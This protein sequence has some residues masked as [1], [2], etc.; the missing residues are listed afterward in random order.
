MINAFKKRQQRKQEASSR[1]QQ[2]TNEEHPDDSRRHQYPQKAWGASRSG[3]ITIAAAPPPSSAMQSSSMVPSQTQQQNL[4]LVLPPASDYRQSLIMPHLTRRFTFLRAPDGSLVS[5]DAMRAHLRAQRARARAATATVAPGTEHPT[6]FL[7]E[8]EENEIIEQ[9]KAQARAEGRDFDLESSLP[10]DSWRSGYAAGTDGFG[11]WGPTGQS[12]SNNL[13]G[14]ADSLGQLECSNNSSVDANSAAQSSSDRSP[15]RKFGG[16]L[17]TARSAER[18]QAY[19]RNVHKERQGSRSEA[20]RPTVGDGSDADALE[21]EVFTDYL[22][23]VASS[24]ID[25]LNDATPM[26]QTFPS[27][28]V[29]PGDFTAAEKPMASNSLLGVPGQGRDRHDR[30]SQDSSLLTTLSPKAFHR[31]STA[32]D[33]VYKLMAAERGSSSTSALGRSRIETAAI[34]SSVDSDNSFASAVSRVNASN[35]HSTHIADIAEDG[36]GSVNGHDDDDEEEDEEGLDLTVMPSGSLDA[37]QIENA[38]LNLAGLSAFDASAT[39]A[40]DQPEGYASRALPISDSTHTV[41]AGDASSTLALSGF[42]GANGTLAASGSSEPSAG[43]MQSSANGKVIG[44]LADTNGGRS[45]GR[46]SQEARGSMDEDQRNSLLQRLRSSRGSHNTASSSSHPSNVVASSSASPPRGVAS[47]Y[48]TH[49]SAELDSHRSSYAAGASPARLG[50]HSRKASAELLASARV[51]ASQLREQPSLSSLRRN[52]RRH[53][54]SATASSDGSILNGFAGQLP[55]LSP[56]ASG[57]MSPVPVLNR[58][59]RSTNYFP[60]PSSSNS[61]HEYASGFKPP[62]A[63][64]PAAAAA[65]QT[66]P[67]SQQGSPASPQNAVFDASH[68]LRRV[69][70]MRDSVST[71]PHPSSPAAPSVPS[72]SQSMDRTFPS[73]SSETGASSLSLG[74]KQRTTS[75]TSPFIVSPSSFGQT[76]FQAQLSPGEM[77]LQHRPVAPPVPSKDVGGENMLMPRPPDDPEQAEKWRAIYGSK[78]ADAASFQASSDDVT[79]GEVRDLETGEDEEDLWT[80]MADSANGLDSRRPVSNFPANL[81]EDQLAGTGITFDQLADYQNRLVQSAQ[82]STIPPLPSSTLAVPGPIPASAPVPA[83]A[84]GSTPSTFAEAKS[85]GLASPNLVLESSSSGWNT[86]ASPPASRTEE[87]ATALSTGFTA[88]SAPVNR[89]V[90]QTSR[91]AAVRFG[92]RSASSST[93]GS[94]TSPRAVL[95]DVTTSHRPTS[96]PLHGRNAS[97]TGLPSLYELNHPIS[98]SNR[99]SLSLAQAQRESHALPSSDGHANFASEAWGSQHAQPAHAS[100]ASLHSDRGIVQDHP[101]NVGYTSPIVSPPS[102]AEAFDHPRTSVSGPSPQNQSTHPG[103]QTVSVDPERGHRSRPSGLDAYAYANTDQLLDD[104]AAQARAATRALKGVDDGSVATP[105]HRTKSIARKKSFR[106]V[107]KQ[108]S[109]PQLISTSQK[110]DHVTQLSQPPPPETPSVPTRLGSKKSR[111]PVWGSIGGGQSRQ[112]A[113]PSTNFSSTGRSNGQYHRRRSSSFGHEA[114]RSESFGLPQGGVD[115]APS[116]PQNRV[117]PGNSNHPYMNGSNASSIS[118]FFSKMKGKKSV[119]DTFGGSTIEPFPSQTT[120]ASSLVQSRQ[121]TAAS[122]EE[123]SEKSYELEMPRKSS[124]GSISRTNTVRSL[125]SPPFYT[126]PID[127]T[128]MPRTR[129][130]KRT[131]IVLKRDSE[132]V[133]P[134]DPGYMPTAI[135]SRDSDHSKSALEAET[136]AESQPR[137]TAAEYSKAEID[138]PTMASVAGEGLAADAAVAAAIADGSA[139]LVDSA[140]FADDHGPSEASKLSGISGAVTPHVPLSQADLSTSGAEAQGRSSSNVPGAVS[141]PTPARSTEHRKSLRDTIV[142]RTIIIPTDANLEELRK[143]YQSL[144]SSRKSRRFG[145]AQHEPVPASASSLGSF[146]LERSNSERV[147]RSNNASEDTSITPHQSSPW[148]SNRASRVESSYAGSLYDMYINDTGGAE[149]SAGGSAANRASRIPETRRHIEVTERADGSVVWQVI[150]GLADRGSVYSDY[151][152][153]HSRGV[154]DASSMAYHGYGSSVGVGGVSEDSRSLFTK[155]YGGR[156]PLASVSRGSGERLERSPPSVMAGLPQQPR[157]EVFE[158]ANPAPVSSPSDQAVGASPTRI[159][160]HTDAQL[161]SLLDILAKGKDS[162]KFEFQISTTNA[163]AENVDTNYPGDQSADPDGTQNGISRRPFSTLTGLVD[164]DDIETHRSRVEAEIY[165]LL[166]QQALVDR[167]RA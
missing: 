131:P 105:P 46:G 157:Q 6:H 123:P 111:S 136:M 52:Y 14:L 77:H 133:M 96:P 78:A 55:T 48:S 22:P 104:V 114:S 23:A 58:S 93:H 49:G 2:A 145:A 163:S 70:Q 37:I 54:R 106:K 113:S 151:S 94:A 1:S 13:S 85:K 110:M 30:L 142:R 160:Y 71:D 33:E 31:V 47:S 39:T 122:N 128:S 158:M 69:Q 166:N 20:T 116:Q 117:S 8:E 56:R 62:S 81:A 84:T 83:E 15:T 59:A 32:L 24:D 43:T 97:L 68:A 141:V 65:L 38:N 16:G 137:A 29:M 61:M 25:D 86:M 79:D 144:N 109:T 41:R 60:P 34:R 45:H 119:E 100:A 124:F 143:S 135:I 107:S 10:S 90:R 147:V 126:K 76:S 53:S 51:Q 82:D 63:I 132:V 26:Q 75:A 73:S 12:H 50:S 138:A 161:A 44:R 21:G 66:M 115:A 35:S 154:S 127:S 108:I 92:N 149:A 112:N 129:S 148:R 9:L 103:H 57:M 152:S 67:G 11:S 140:N 36:P 3:G 89:H 118:R 165:T 28:N 121:Q 27:Q 7:T 88:P 167:S 101:F 153:R 64:S 120:A 91:D 4:D 80:R 74:Q 162:A 134:G 130:K 72:F 99:G 164:A 125:K 156:K 150:A 159:V 102:G 87:L 95:Y 155:P 17:F 5:P 139:P 98:R 42:P 40:V 19:L 18:D 146:G